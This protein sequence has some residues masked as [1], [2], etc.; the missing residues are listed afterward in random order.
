MEKF[1]DLGISTT[2][3]FSS[4]NMFDFLFVPPPCEENLHNR[5]IQDLNVTGL[6]FK[7]DSRNWLSAQR[8]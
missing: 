8:E 1:L 5:F 7:W 3:A 2:A 6:G 4:S